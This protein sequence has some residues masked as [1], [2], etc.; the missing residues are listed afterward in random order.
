MFNPFQ[1]RHLF[2]F[3]LK[4]FARPAGKAVQEKFKWRHNDASPF[5]QLDILSNAISPINEETESRQPGN[6]NREDWLNTVDLLIT[7]ACLVKS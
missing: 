3:F 1:L 5:H 2:K 7:I 6:I 4:G